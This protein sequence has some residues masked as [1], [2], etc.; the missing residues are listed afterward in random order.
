LQVPWDAHWGGEV[1]LNESFRGTLSTLMA[2]CNEYVNPCQCSG[3]R[4]PFDIKVSQI[5]MF[6]YILEE[7]FFEEERETF[8]I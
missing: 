5:K 4:W 1:K 3:V 6:L 7:N 2:Q 8:R